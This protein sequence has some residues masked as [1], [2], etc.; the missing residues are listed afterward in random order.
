[1]PGQDTPKITFY[2][3]SSEE[4][5]SIS[6]TAYSNFH[7]PKH[8]HNHYT[9][10]FIEAGINEGFTESEGYR[11]GR[12]S[13]L[14]I[15]PG[16][17]HAGNSFN[18]SYLQFK[19]LRIEPQFLNYFC[20]LNEGPKKGDIRFETAPV[21]N[22]SLSRQLEGLL[23]SMVKPSAE[24]DSSLKLHLFLRTLITNYSNQGGGVS[25]KAS[26]QIS[27]KRAK[28]FIQDNYQKDFS[29]QEL[30]RYSLLSPYH[31]ARQFKK[32]YGLSPFQYLRNF[33]VEKA[34]ELLRNSSSITQ[35]ALEVGFFDHSHFL[36]NF[37]KMEGTS[38]SRI[39]RGRL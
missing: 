14:I 18:N 22:P 32:Q 7:F 33:R 34:K 6:Q 1:M 27:L 26:C 4:G 21:Y 9:I 5:L 2:N 13:I 15:N 25:P 30:A 28:E 35:V 12:G 37:R 16:D 36:R 11:I 38:P 17:L 29:L 10:L 19:S 31:L 20:E 3:H 8:F 23:N 24:L 39:K